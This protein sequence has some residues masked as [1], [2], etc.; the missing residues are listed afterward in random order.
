MS[1]NLR[2][3]AARSKGDLIFERVG[4]QARLQAYHGT[5]L[6]PLEVKTEP[7][8]HYWTDAVEKMKQSEIKQLVLDYNNRYAKGIAGSIPGFR[9]YPFDEGDMFAA[10]LPSGQIAILAIKKIESHTSGVHLSVLYLDPL[11]ALVGTGRTEASRNSTADADKWWR[12]DGNILDSDHVPSQSRMT[13]EPDEANNKASRAISKTVK[14]KSPES[15][16]S[17]KVDIAIDDRDLEVTKLSDRIFEAVIILRN[18]G[19]VPI[20][21]F[22]VNFCAGDPDK[23]GRLLATHAAGPIMV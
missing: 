14:V 23:G 9:L 3:L 16:E 22:R 6:S 15:T 12:P 10:V 11:L 1:G 13:V 4:E 19:S 21:R 2:A 18:K 7:P 8:H 20:P 17:T 5:L